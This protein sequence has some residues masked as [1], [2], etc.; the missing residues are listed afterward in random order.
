MAEIY[1]KNK[2]KCRTNVQQVNTLFKMGEELENWVVAND[3]IAI[4]TTSFGI[5]IDYDNSGRTQII[6]NT[7]YYTIFY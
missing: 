4:T 6:D 5:T 7:D 2:F 1:D 3:G